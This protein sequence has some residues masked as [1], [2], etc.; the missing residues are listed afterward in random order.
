MT[1]EEPRVDREVTVD[2]VEVLTEG[3]P[4]VG[5]ARDE[6]LQGHALDAGEHAGQVL[7]LAG[8]DRRD[9]EAA[10][11]ADDAGHA[12]ERRRRSRG[13]PQDLGVVVG[14]NVDKPGGHHEPVG[15]DRGGRGV[16]NRADRHHA[17]VLDAHVG[18][19]ARAAGPVDDLAT[20]DH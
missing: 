12:V 13:V 2:A 9:R 15:V 5:D 10:V 18:P 6:G 7:G 11:P 19:P 4:V 3:A 1:D 20:A 17:A 14:V 16:V 8:F